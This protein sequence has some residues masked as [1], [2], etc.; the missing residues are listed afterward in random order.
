[1]TTGRKIKWD[2]ATERILDDP[3]AAKLLTREYREGFAR[4]LEA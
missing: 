1:M 4:Q 2:P 3:D